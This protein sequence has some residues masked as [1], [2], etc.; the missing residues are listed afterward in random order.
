MSAYT[1]WEW[2]HSIDDERWYRAD[3]RE[4]AIDCLGGEGGYVGEHCQHILQLAKFINVDRMIENAIERMDE[5]YG[6]LE[7][8]SEWDI[9]TK[10]LEEVIKIAVQAWQVTKGVKIE[11]WCFAGS[12][13]VEYIEATY[14]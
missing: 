13:N 7:G 8:G 9:D 11:S 6:D 10:G 3:S 5:D 14:E 4:D 12:R 2:Y 1:D